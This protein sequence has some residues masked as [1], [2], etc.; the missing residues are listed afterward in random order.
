M[1]L[2]KKKKVTVWKLVLELCEKFNIQCLYKTVFIGAILFTT[3]MAEVL[4]WDT[5]RWV[6][7]S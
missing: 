1:H 7:L 2:K 4:D 5:N 6:R 3:E